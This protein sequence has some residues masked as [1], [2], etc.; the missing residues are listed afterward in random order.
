MVVLSVILGFIIGTSLGS[1]VFLFA[2][3]GAREAAYWSFV[4]QHPTIEP[5]AKLSVTACILACGVVFAYLGYS[6]SS[7]PLDPSPRAVP[8]AGSA[9][10][11]NA[12]TA[13]PSRA[14]LSW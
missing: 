14:P 10:A 5:L 6:W 4:K 8:A 9:G 3:S 11:T 1:S 7:H 2:L 12:V 13:R